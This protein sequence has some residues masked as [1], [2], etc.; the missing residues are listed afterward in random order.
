MTP[1]ALKRLFTVDEFHRMGEAGVF[2]D[3]DRVELL[4]GEIITMTPIG[5]RH[6]SC[7][8]RLIATLAPLVGADAILDVQNPLPLAAQTEPQ[9]DVVLLKPRSDYYRDAHPG[10]SEVLLVIEV[11]DSSADHDRAVKVPQYARAGIAELWVVNLPER[12]IEVYRQPAAGEYAE[13]V[14]V[15]PGRTLRLPGLGH[16][17]IVVDDVLV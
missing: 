7:V 5:P 16:R 8:R 14:A 10:P 9:P 2:Q 13:H 1:Q 15:G 6:A 3:D 4:E 17:Q 11:A 12:L